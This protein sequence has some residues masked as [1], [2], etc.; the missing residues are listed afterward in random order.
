MK[1]H[2]PPKQGDAD[3]S[4]VW[5]E[6]QTLTVVKDTV[7]ISRVN[8]TSNQLL[9]HY[10]GLNCFAQI[11]KILLSKTTLNSYSHKASGAV[12]RGSVSCSK[13]LQLIISWPLYLLSHYL[14]WFV[15]MCS[16][17]V[18]QETCSSVLLYCVQ[19]NKNKDKWRGVFSVFYFVQ[20]THLT[21][22]SSF[23]LMALILWYL[24]CKR[25]WSELFTKG[26]VS[27]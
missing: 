13:A 18:C 24:W 26:S 1:R 20:R 22:C 21:Y 23:I 2:W 15:C 7:R 27:F 16:L 12:H 14:Q 11:W 19:N 8:D 3:S 17:R 6:K 4:P 25:Q 5:C 9:K 10:G